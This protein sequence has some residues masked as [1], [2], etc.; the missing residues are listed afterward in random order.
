M[1]EIIKKIHQKQLLTFCELNKFYKVKE[2]YKILPRKHRGLYWL[3][4]N[5]DYQIL[6]KTATKANTRQVPIDKL[7]SQRDG[8]KNI[9]KIEQQDFKIVYNGI[10]GFKKQP[11]T[12]GLRERINQEI[13]CNDRRTGTL[14][15][16][17]RGFNKNNWAVSFFD[18][19]D[20]ENQ[21][22]LKPL[23]TKEPY[24]DFA[25]DLE[26]LW[27]LEYGTPILCRH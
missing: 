4:T 5:V 21:N 14:N 3:W 20:P 19:D 22:I 13:N 23:K 12:F 1:K 15:I 17:N 16:I 24:L 26:M 11:P 10:G 27:R 2:H 7:V 6:K 9:A 25:K 8:L 18:F